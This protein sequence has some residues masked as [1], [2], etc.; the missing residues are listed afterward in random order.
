MIVS[1]GTLSGCSIDGL[2]IVLCNTSGIR[3]IAKNSIDKLKAQS[4]DWDK[5]IG[6]LFRDYKIRLQ[7]DPKEAG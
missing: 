3:R 4:S 6:S 5:Q 2:E 1:A 7:F